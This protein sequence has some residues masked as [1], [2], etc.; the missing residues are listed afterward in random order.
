MPKLTKKVIDALEPGE[1]D[2]VEWDDQLK[3]FGLR[4]WPSGKKTFILMYRSKKG[5]ARKMT[6]G[7]YGKLTPD[8]ARDA[9]KQALGDVAAGGDPAMDRS[10]ARHGDTMADLAKDYIERHARPHKKPTSVEADCRFFNRII[11]PY[12]GKRKVKDITRADIGKF[13]HAHQSTPVQANRCLSL[14][15]KLFSLAEEWGLRP[16]QT[17]PC[18]HVQRYK[19]RKIERYLSN[20]E[21]TM[22]GQTLAEV[23]ADA[24]EMSSA[25]LAIRLLLLT[26]CR[27]SEILSLQWADVDLEAGLLRLKDSKTGPKDVPIPLPAVDVFLHAPRLADNPFVCF[28]AKEKAR[29]IGI[30]K[31]WRRIRAKAGLSD[32]RLHDLR[33]NFAS[34]AAA[35]GLG[36]PIIGALLGHSQAQTT[37][38]YAHLSM[39]PLKAASDE[40]ARRISEAMNQEP[41][42]RGAVVPFRRK[43]K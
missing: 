29:L 11:L 43:R 25:I 16:E 27:V 37:Q 12:F 26:G 20:E 34:V 23:E 6:L 41:K 13:H 15:S 3:G 40:V 8:Q 36:L 30:E 31:I 24:S 19:E 35:A 9:A 39:D 33:H 2:Y 18:K 1:H 10:E 17:N 7:Q 28:G 22:L 42:K 21:M 38:R 14:L 32:V 5:Q 4:V